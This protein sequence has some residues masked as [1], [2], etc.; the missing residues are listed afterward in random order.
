MSAEQMEE[1]WT[2]DKAAPMQPLSHPLIF[3][4]ILI[5]PEPQQHPP[6]KAMLTGP[7]PQSHYTDTW[8]FAVQRASSGASIQMCSFKAGTLTSLIRDIIDN[9]E[10]RSAKGGFGFNSPPLFSVP[11]GRGGRTAERNEVNQI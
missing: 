8:A 3:S 1:G 5:R 4:L 10:E 7:E 11:S 6:H 2:V 9:N